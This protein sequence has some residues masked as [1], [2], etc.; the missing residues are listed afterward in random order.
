MESEEI[1]FWRAEFY[2]W[3]MIKKKKKEETPKKYI[4]NGGW[5]ASHHGD[6]IERSETL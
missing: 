3:L 5:E 6:M 4:F 2:F 1:T